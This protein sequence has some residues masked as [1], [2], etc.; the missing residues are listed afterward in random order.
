[1]IK[2][3]DYGNFA[4]QSTHPLRGATLRPETFKRLQLFQSTHPL[5]GATWR[6]GR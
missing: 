4:F 1:M 3:T 6:K 2:G 5:R